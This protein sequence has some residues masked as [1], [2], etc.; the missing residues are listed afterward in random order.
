MQTIRDVRALFDQFNEELPIIQ[1]D[2]NSQT[3]VN[4]GRIRGNLVHV[5]EYRATGQSLLW[6]S[7]QP[8][9][10][11]EEFVL[12]NEYDAVMVEVV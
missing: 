11:N 10:T 2:R 8:M 7:L 3:N 12:V 6:V 4:P 1:N 9:N 5:Y